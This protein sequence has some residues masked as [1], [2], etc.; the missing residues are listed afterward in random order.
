[1]ERAQLIFCDMPPFEGALD[2]CLRSFWVEL[3]PPRRQWGAVLVVYSY[4]CDEIVIGTSEQSAAV[5]DRDNVIFVSE[6]DH[7]RIVGAGPPG[8]E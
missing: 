6:K 8:L 1:M 2:A 5:R 3:H 7:R 4:G